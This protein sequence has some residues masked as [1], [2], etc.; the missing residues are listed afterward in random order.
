Y[1]VGGHQVVAGEAIASH[2][3]A[4]ASTQRQSGNTGV[5]DS[6]TR[7]GQAIHLG[8]TVDL[9]PQ[10]ASLRPDETP[11][12]IDANAFHGTQIQHEP[13]VTG[14]MAGSVMAPA[15]DGHEQVVG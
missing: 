3:P 8:F 7:G 12:R 4:D 5:V 15:A 11:D 9:P 1:H 13:P 2:Q 14:G 6:P 10:D